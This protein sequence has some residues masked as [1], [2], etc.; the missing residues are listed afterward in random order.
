VGRSSAPSLSGSLFHSSLTL[1][2]VSPLLATH[3]ETYPGGRTPSLPAVVL[4][5]AG[6]SLCAV[7]SAQAYHFGN[8]RRLSMWKIVM[9]ALG[10]SCDALLRTADFA[11]QRG[12]RMRSARDLARS[13]A[14]STIFS[15][16]PIWSRVCRSLCGSGSMPRFRSDSSS[17]SASL[18][19]SRS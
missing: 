8:A 14:M 4:V 19:P 15:S 11:F 2:P 12:W 10:D 3:T 17:S 9:I 16:A 13:R 6:D 5:K 1:A 18:I 7:A